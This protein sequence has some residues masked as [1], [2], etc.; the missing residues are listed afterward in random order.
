MTKQITVNGKTYE[1][2][3]GQVIVGEHTINVLFSKPWKEAPANVLSKVDS[4]VLEGRVWTGSCFVPSEVAEA[5][6]EMKA[7]MRAAE[8]ASLL[9]NVPGLRELESAIAAWNNYHHEFSRMM[10]DEYNDGVNP[11]KKPT[12]DVDEIRAKYPVAAAYLKAQSYAYASHYAKV[13]AGEKAVERIANGEDYKIVID[14]MEAEWSQAAHE[15]V[16]NS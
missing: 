13:A 12:V 15:S 6:L 2:K 10:D 5:A 1:I 7:E 11:P 3:D 9:A 4:A 16:M 8:E 14:E